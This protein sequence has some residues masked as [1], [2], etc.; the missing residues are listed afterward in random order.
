MLRLGILGGSFDPVHHGH[1]ILARD[2]AEALRLDRLVFVPAAV[3]PFKLDHAPVAA[4]ELRLA[5]LR[6]AV[7]GEERFAV[8]DCELR[9]AGPS[10]TIDTVLE[11]QERSPGA[12]IFL[13][14]GTDNV[15]ALP[16]W[17]RF[18]ELRTQAQF[19]V[20]RRETDAEASVGG[21]RTLTTRRVDISATEIRNRVAAGQPIRYLVPE[22][23]RALIQAHRLYVPSPLPG[24]L[25]PSTPKP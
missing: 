9:R 4:G 25:S 12:E 2:A 24:G 15:P 21:W 8:D 17:H 13:L 14:I 7:A 19:V 23:V 18:E 3:N 22:A 11:L 5:M 6:A 10:F 1:L 20:L 16:R